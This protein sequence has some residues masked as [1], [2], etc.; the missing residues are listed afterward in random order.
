MSELIM[1]IGIAIRNPIFLITKSNTNENAIGMKINKGKM[2]NKQKNK[3]RKFRLAIE[4]Y[5]SKISEVEK[6]FRSGE[7]SQILK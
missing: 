1:K 7:F 3:N 4:K 5:F 6:L 2:V